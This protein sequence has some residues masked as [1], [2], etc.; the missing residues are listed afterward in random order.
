MTI[1]ACGPLL[2]SGAILLLAML[3]A[4]VQG[5]PSTGSCRPSQVKFIASS[6]DHSTT[7]FAFVNIPETQIN[8]TQ[9]GAAASCVLVRFSASTHG[10]NGID[11]VNVRA[12]LDSTAGHPA[13]IKVRGETDVTGYPRSFEFIFPSVP[14]GAHV[15]RMQFSSDKGAAVHVMNHNTV[16]QYTP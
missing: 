11:V 7:S 13:V 3:P 8:F 2:C 4:V 5:A 1:R 15:L 14:P 16:I 9:G 6:L 12:L 10:T